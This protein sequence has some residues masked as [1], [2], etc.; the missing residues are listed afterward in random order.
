MRSS[1]RSSDRSAWP[2]PDATEYVRVPVTS[3]EYLAKELG[4]AHGEMA[5]DLFAVPP[6][7]TR[8]AWAVGYVD[9][10][11]LGPRESSA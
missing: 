11:L 2:E 3:L 10:L 9:G 5:A 7:R 8:I 6:L 1:D 4:R